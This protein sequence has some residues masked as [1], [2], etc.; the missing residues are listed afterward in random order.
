[1][2]D[3]DFGEI[4]YIKN[5]INKKGYIGQAVCYTGK[6]NKKWGSFNRWKTHIREAYS[7]KKDRCKLLNQAIRKYN[8]NNF[9]LNILGK[10]H[11]NKL[12]TMEQKYIQEYNTL[13]PHGYNLNKGGY[14][15]KDSKETI[16]KKRKMRLGKKNNKTHIE[17]SRIGQIGNRR[18]IK[19]RKYKNDEKLPK[20]INAI[21]KNG[22]ITNYV[23]NKFPIG[24]K[25]K[26]YLNFRFKTLEEAINK[27][28]ELKIEYAYI[29]EEIRKKNN[30]LKKKKIQEK[31]LN[32]KKLKKLPE[33]IER[34][35][36]DTGK[37]KGYKVKYK[38]NEKIF[39]GKTNTWNLN[40]ARKYLKLLQIDEINNKF[41]IP[42]LP[43]YVYL[44]K[45]KEKTKIIGFEMRKPKQK[46]IIHPFLTL[47]QKYNKILSEIKSMVT[48][49]QD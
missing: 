47:E 41:T 4:Y 37:I 7:D 13:V 48:D 46:K 28:N 16:E 40:S 3:L 49:S 12:D 20:Y 23:I 34:I 5:L 35:F 30:E 10:F 22:I 18:K 2:E 26:K 24:I 29:E 1:M 32:N 19:K 8:E 27:L 15:G 9:K 36:T 14:G 6:N 33:Y 38:D 21:R 43:P 11:L 25:E 42:K 39:T 17:N 31:M 45:N 44:V